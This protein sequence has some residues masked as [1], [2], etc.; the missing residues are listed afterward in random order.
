MVFC[1]AELVK[2]LP[3]TW[4]TWIQSL[5]WEDPLEKEMATGSEEAVPGPPVFPSGEPGDIQPRQ[6]GPSEAQRGVNGQMVCP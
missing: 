2:N 1:M 6:N 3:T 4:E 5:C